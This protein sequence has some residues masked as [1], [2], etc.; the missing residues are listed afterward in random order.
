MAWKYVSARLRLSEQ[1]SRTARGAVPTWRKMVG[2]GSPS[3]PLDDAPSSANGRLGE[4]SL[5]ET[6]TT[7]SAR[8]AD[9]TSR[10]PGGFSGLRVD[11]HESM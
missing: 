9:P 5:P 7:R 3:P 10:Q 11:G 4:P 1:I 2:R 6:E 8:S